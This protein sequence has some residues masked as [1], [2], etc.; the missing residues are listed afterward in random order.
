MHTLSAYVS[1]ILLILLTFRFRLITELN[2]QASTG[3]KP[4]MNMIMR[5]GMRLFILVFAVMLSACASSGQ[6]LSKEK[7]KDDPYADSTLNSI[8]ASQKVQTDRQI[9]KRGY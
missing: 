1:T 7:P 5:Y 3:L 4:N 2:L 8:K 6:E 9:Y